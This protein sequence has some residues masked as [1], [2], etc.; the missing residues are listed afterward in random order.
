VSGV[1][2]VELLRAGLEA[3]AAVLRTGRRPELAGPLAGD[4][5]LGRLLYELVSLDRFA[6]AVSNGDLDQDLEMRGSVAGALKSLQAAL[7]HLTWQ[8]QRVA[9]GDF[10]QRVDF[11]G[12]L[13]EAFNSMVDALG[14]MRSQLDQRNEQLIAQA[15]KLEE[16]ATTNVLTGVFN[17]RTFNELIRDEFERVARYGR[18]LSFVI[19]DIDEFKLVNDSLGHEVGDQVL[20]S[21]AAFVRDGIRTVD[22]L[23]RWGGEEFVLLL[24][25]V[26]R[27]AA[28]D[29]AERLRAGV[30]DARLPGDVT[31][32]CGVAEH[33]P[34][35]TPDDLF[36][37]A[38]RALYRAKDLGR[39]R[40][41]AAD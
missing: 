23:A 40:V 34:P 29:V 35:E 30:R 32:S 38:D 26:E 18:P 15:F 4:A 25:Q 20:V 9:A 1:T 33:H 11:M 16:L 22:S 31:V 7:R 5:E 37:R 24:P 3:V 2:D 8:S 19:M 28:V 36:A 6:L 21:L 39:D 10:T 14:E 17:R 13:S 41:E 12:D 27:D